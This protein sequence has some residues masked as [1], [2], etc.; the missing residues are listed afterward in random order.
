MLKFRQSVQKTNLMCCVPHGF[1]AYMRI[2]GTKTRPVMFGDQAILA[3][4]NPV[5]VPSSA[6]VRSV[7]RGPQGNPLLHNESEAV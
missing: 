6:R 1:K 3:S 2:R 5:F 4:N 7:R